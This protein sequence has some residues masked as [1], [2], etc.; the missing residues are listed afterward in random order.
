MLM[1]MRRPPLATNK[2][3]HIILRGVGDIK[4]FK[5]ESDYYRAIFSIYEFNTTTPIEIRLQR[6]KRQTI[7]KHGGQ[8]SDTRDHLVDILA[9]CFMPN[10][11]HLLIKQLKDN[12]ITQFMKKVGTGYAT[13]FNKKYS[14]RGHLFQNRF[15]A[16]R[17]KDDNQ[18]KIVFAY[19]H[20]NPISLIESEWKE[21]GI[22]D[23]NK[24][25]KFLENYKWS[26]YLDYIGGKAFPSITNRD[27]VNEMLNGV[28]GCREFIN[29]VWIKY[30]G[31][32]K[33]FID[34]LLE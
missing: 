32:I 33:E 26:S 5:D 1:A 19:I 9:F 3:Y 15:Q 22:I 12:G 13:Y 2:I 11:I 31:R 18:L 29:D 28:V 20:S 14:R 16:V 4:I 6:E 21:N 34:S 30:K 23:L 24:V 10:H 8:S 7:K 17:I 25:I 27:L